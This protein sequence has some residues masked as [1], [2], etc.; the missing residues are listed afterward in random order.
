MPFC[1]Y[2]TMDILLN[3]G[4]I[5]GDIFIRP[6]QLNVDIDEHSRDEYEER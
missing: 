2:E 3:Y 5:Y 4:A 1:Q 6:L